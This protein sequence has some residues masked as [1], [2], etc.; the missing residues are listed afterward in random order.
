MLRQ[1]LASL[2]LGAKLIAAVMLLTAALTLFR[3]LRLGKAV[4]SVM[5]TAMVILVAVLSTLALVVGLGWAAPRPGRVWNHLRIAGD[6]LIDHGPDA[7][8][9]VL[10][11]VDAI[12]GAASMLQY[13]V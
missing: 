12:G 9:T 13:L 5:S 2:G 11:L 4:G 8:R 7:L 1:L 3:W 6:V 10:R